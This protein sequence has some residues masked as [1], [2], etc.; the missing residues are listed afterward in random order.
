SPIPLQT[1]QNCPRLTRQRKTFPA[2]PYSNLFRQTLSPNLPNQSQNPLSRP[3]PSQLKS[4]NPNP[5]PS[6]SPSLNPS[7]AQSVPTT[8]RSPLPCSR[9]AVPPRQA[10]PPRPTTV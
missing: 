9:A 7:Q 2:V 10:P 3:S 8:D 5:K 6:R 1:V 4:P